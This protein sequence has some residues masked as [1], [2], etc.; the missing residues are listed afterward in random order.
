M[1]GFL[2]IVLAVVVIAPAILVAIVVYALKWQRRRMHIIA[3]RA[4]AIEAEA[5]ET[6][7]TKRS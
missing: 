4:G 6:L 2:L 3:R 1:S 5:V 7:P